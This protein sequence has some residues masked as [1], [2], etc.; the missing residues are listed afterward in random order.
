MAT[1]NSWFRAL[2][3]ATTE[4]EVVSQ[5]RD[6]CALLHPRDLAALPEDVR[7]IHVENAGDIPRLRER[8]EACSLVARTS[9]FDADKVVDL[10]AFISRASVKLGEF[11]S[12]PRL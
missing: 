7:Q 6:F 2:E 12:I 5:A 3:R 9:A 10:L 4:A 11:R 8:L 1:M